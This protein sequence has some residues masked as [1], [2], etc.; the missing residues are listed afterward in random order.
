MLEETM[1]E[2]EQPT[3]DIRPITRR[4]YEQLVDLGWFADEKLELLEGRLV[5]MSPQ[6]PEHAEIV[7]T[8]TE[9]LAVAVAGRARVR[10][11]LPFALDELSEPEPDLAIV[12]LA[13]YRAA[14]PGRALLV[15][16]VA[17]TALRKDR[18]I[19]GRL[20]AAAG[21]PEYWVVDVVAHAID[22]HT[23]PTA[24]GYEK[25]QR[26]TDGVIEIASLP[27]VTVDV[28]VVVGVVP[29]PHR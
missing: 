22:V 15:I 23:E 28:S 9:L 14:H 27:G 19:K 26:V 8:L 12:P 7:G 20:Y 25:A 5:R 17:D 13:S 18:R 11:Q 1:S 29:D 10:P 6:G 3:D 4:E 16:E 21:I 24:K 2:A